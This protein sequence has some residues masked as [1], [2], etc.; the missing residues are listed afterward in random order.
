MYQK[1]CI[2][3]T[4]EMGIKH[5]ASGKIAIHILCNTIVLIHCDLEMP[6]DVGNYGHQH[7]FR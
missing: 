5:D 7:W 1:Y 3:L 4:G 6:H 2:Y